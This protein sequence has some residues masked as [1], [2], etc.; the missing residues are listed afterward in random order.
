[1][2]IKYINNKSKA[3]KKGII[4][5]KASFMVLLSLTLTSCKS[6]EVEV[7]EGY[8]SSSSSYKHKEIILDSLESEIILR[9]S[10]LEEIKEDIKIEE[11]IE[12]QTEEK[13]KKLVAITFDDGPSKYTSEL[14]D[15]LNE[16][17]AHATFFLIGSNIEKNKDAVSKAYSYG[18]EI[19][20]H[21]YSHKSF[22]KMTIEEIISEIDLTKSLIENLDVEPADLV[23]PPY[24]NIND[25]IKSNVDYP[26]ILWNVDTRDWESRDKEKV[27]KEVL[28]SIKEGDIILFH[29]AYPSTI[30][31]VKE[32]L[33]Q[34]EEYEFVTVSELFERN[35][36]KL[37][38]NNKYYKV[39]K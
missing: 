6:N 7:V 35:D 25:D 24:G 39:K 22:T 38:P 28:E 19:A 36:I 10:E 1:M 3:Y 13:Q 12:E 5:K 37:E 31:A 33:P 20:I 17:G 16:N 21:T 11:N 15:I 4:L 14:I 29:D 9:N 26:F 18:N 30:E 34:L 8:T 27:K 23:R 2:K 32:L